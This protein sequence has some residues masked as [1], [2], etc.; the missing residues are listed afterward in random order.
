MKTIL[1]IAMLVTLASCNGAET[2]STK[3]PDIEA[4][5]SI[6]EFSWIRP[7]GN[8]NGSQ[9]YEAIIIYETTTSIVLYTKTPQGGVNEVISQVDYDSVVASDS[10]I[11]ATDRND[12]SI[13][14]FAHTVWAD[15]QIRI[16]KGSDPCYIYDRLEPGDL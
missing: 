16:C 1:M 7:Y 2:A 12:A 4:R 10:L 5:E 6:L 11:V 13:I 14:D 15:K 3:A 9:S 8:H